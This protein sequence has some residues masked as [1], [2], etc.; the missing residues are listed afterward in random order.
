MNDELPDLSRHLTLAC[1]EKLRCWPDNLLGIA[2]AAFGQ[3][4]A[5]HVIKKR[6]SI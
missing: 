1:A 6:S 3:C 5:I 4:I 2:I